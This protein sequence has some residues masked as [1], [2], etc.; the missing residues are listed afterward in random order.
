MRQQGRF[1]VVLVAQA[2]I[3]IAALALFAAC[4]LRSNVLPRVS[5]V[6]GGSISMYPQYP[7]LL[8]GT[9]PILVGSLYLAGGYQV[10]RLHSVR[11]IFYAIAKAFV[12]ALPVVLA[13]GFV[14]RGQT[15]S[16][17]IV[18]L[19]LAL[20]YAAFFALRFATHLFMQRSYL[21]GKELDKA[22]IV[23]T[24]PGAQTIARAIRQK[25]ATMNLQMIQNQRRKKMNS[26]MNMKMRTKRMNSPMKK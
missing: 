22:I 19:Y 17:A 6:W 3:L 18:F 9:L 1:D 12:L 4:L 11:R 10:P 16:R 7:L 25:K 8:L 24:G 23:G 14:L 20:S 13:L 5:S 26:P 21:R 2:D 15:F